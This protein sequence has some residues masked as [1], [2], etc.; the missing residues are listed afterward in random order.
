MDTIAA[1]A[2]APGRGGIGIVRLSGPEALRI[3]EALAGRTLRARHAHHAVFRDRNG[4]ALDDGIAI[5]FRG[6]ASFTGEDVVELQGHGG[7]AVLDAVLRACLDLGARVARPGEF[8]ERAFL[9]D[10]LDLAQAEAIAD[11]IDAASREAATAALKSLQGVFSER[12]RALMD[13]TT[14]LRVYV[15]AAID[16]P[17]EEVDFLAD[18]DVEG[19]IEALCADLAALR[20]EARR[21]ALLTDGM[22][23]VLA[24]APNAGKSS[25]LNALARRDTAI[26]TDVPGTTRDV[27]RERIDLDGMPLHVVDT[28]GLRLTQDRV[29]AEGVRRARAEIERADALLYVIDAT[30]ADALPA[31]RAALA[32]LAE[33]ELPRHVLLLLNKVDLREERGALS[34]TVPIVE[35]SARTGEGL[36]DLIRA[37]EQM[38]G[39]DAGEASAFTARAR[40]LEALADADAAFAAGLETLVATGAGD[41]VAEDLRRGHDALGLIVGAMTPDDLLG[42]IFSSFCIGK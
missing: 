7:P 36:R 23:I 31:D 12:V 13:A 9:N 2:T 1:V 15:E 14:A 17:D 38:A 41:L 34:S 24:G 32:A 42:E 39:F 21:G 18:G 27:L 26:V 33:V 16:F 22:T 5:A 35:T 25:L 3:G 40:H 10:R 30:T 8:S 6:P 11:L 4:L 28:A 37:L 29:E 20:E 19:R